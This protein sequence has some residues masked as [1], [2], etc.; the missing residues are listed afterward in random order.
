MISFASELLTKFIQE[1]SLKLAQYDM[2]H[3]PTLGE[4]YEEITKHGI[5]KE[6]VIPKSLDLRVVKGFVKMGHER[7]PQQIDCMLVVG[8]G[9]KYGLTEQYYYDIENILCIFEV[10]KTLQKS[11]FVDAYDHLGSIRS[12]F[13]QHFEER[14]LA[15]NFQPK[16]SHARKYFA[17]L[18][19]KIAPETYAEIH[20]LSQAD[21]LLFYAL[22]QEEN[23]PVSIVH[24]YGGYKTEEGL[25]TVFIDMIEDRKKLDGRGLGI[26]SIPSLVISNNFC[27][28]KA[29]GL[30]YLT[31]K[32]NNEWIAVFSTRHNPARV[33]LELIWEKISIWFDVKMPYGLD[34][35]IENASPLLSAVPTERLGEVGWV[36]KSHEF[37]EKNL[38]RDEMQLWEPAAV[39]QAEVAAIG[40]MGFRGGYL[41]LD[42]EL[43][44]FFQ[45]HH[46]TTLEVVTS[47]LL[48]TRMFAKK[49]N[50]LRPLSGH[51]LL[52]TND[53]DSGYVALERHRLDAWCAQKGI[54]PHYINIVLVDE[55]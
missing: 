48:L 30:P 2:P 6:F 42:A 20:E 54:A 14:L 44:S 40:L 21:G 4:A 24:G 50:S 10:K 22:V 43:D 37:K 15:G 45:K 29:N 27:L 3:M 35:D 13:S 52:L 36:Y 49:N 7:L 33:I 55:L 1:E 17:Q 26:P 8:E 25:R 23:A 47:N 16:I 39:G 28:V 18:T 12:K 32:D 31:M 34:L 19:G 11:D 41:E 5:D 38:I 53:D 9:E 51:T 46:G